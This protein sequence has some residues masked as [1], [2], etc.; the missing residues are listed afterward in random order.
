MSVVITG[1]DIYSEADPDRAVAY[2]SRVGGG[3]YKLRRVDGGKIDDGAG[4]V[5]DRFDSYG[6]AVAAGEVYAAYLASPEGT[7]AAKDAKLAAMAARIA[8]LEARVSTS[9]VA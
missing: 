4:G 2:V 5:H 9:D 3:Q 6:D 1:A 8:E 7:H